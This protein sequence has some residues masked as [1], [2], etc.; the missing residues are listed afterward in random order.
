MTLV[1]ECSQSKTW[2]PWDL[3]SAFTV[4]THMLGI[5]KRLFG[6][7]VRTWNN[8]VQKKAFFW[9]SWPWPWKRRHL[10]NFPYLSKDYHQHHLKWKGVTFNLGWTYL[11]IFNAHINFIFEMYLEW[12]M[13]NPDME[14][15]T[16]KNAWALGHQDEQAWH[17]SVGVKQKSEW[18]DIEFQ[19]KVAQLTD[20]YESIRINRC[21]SMTWQSNFWWP[22][23]MFNI[24]YKT[25]WFLM[26][27]FFSMYP[28]YTTSPCQKR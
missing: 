20:A 17:Y 19:D 9:A 15:W 11:Y 10:G 12:K 27:A 28:Y 22:C 5:S 1:E 4:E 7:G 23:S 24:Y 21:T 13:W 18:K 25:K 6:H 14:A 2:E 16:R 26:F 8:L 3:K